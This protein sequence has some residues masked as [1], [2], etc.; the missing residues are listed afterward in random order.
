MNASA[1]DNGDPANIELASH[2]YRRALEIDP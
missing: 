2:A 1:L